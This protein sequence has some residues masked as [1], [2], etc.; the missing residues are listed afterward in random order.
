MSIRDSMLSVVEL[1]TTMVE[2]DSFFTAA[3][4]LGPSSE[5]LAVTTHV[6]D[7]VSA[8]K[9]NEPGRVSTAQSTEESRMAR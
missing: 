7:E 3:T 5:P 9:A 4:S 6:V 8:A 2:Q 1:G